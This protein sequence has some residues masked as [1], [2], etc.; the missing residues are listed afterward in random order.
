MRFVVIILVFFLLPVLMFSSE[1]RIQQGY[2]GTITFLD[3]EGYVIQ[4]IKTYSEERI[5]DSAGVSMTAVTRAYASANK[6]YAAVFR[7]V[8]SG[9]GASGRFADIISSEL[10]L[11]YDN[12][13]QRWKKMNIAPYAE[14]N[15]CFARDGSRLLAVLLE[16]GPPEA[17]IKSITVFNSNGSEA[18]QSESFGMPGY[19]KLS[20]NGKYAAFSYTRKVKSA[21]GVI[22]DEKGSVFVD[23]D[24][25]RINQFR[26]PAGAQ[27]AVPNVTD[28]GKCVVTEIKPAKVGGFKVKQ[29]EE[30]LYEYTFGVL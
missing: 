27:R 29:I 14:F 30:V 12:G 10:S 21:D 20:P 16:P 11:L 23:I 1:A 25:K 15:L 28:Q 5:F 18:W 19:M 24:K 8:Y 2:D 22:S 6:K 4:E 26:L 13:E 17:K 9:R 3:E 7:T